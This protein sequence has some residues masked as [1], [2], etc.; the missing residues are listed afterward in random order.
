M[1]QYAQEKYTPSLL[2]A[3]GGAQLKL[4][5]L[6]CG[7]HCPADLESTSGRLPGTLHRQDI[8]KR[9]NIFVCVALSY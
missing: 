8:S 7:G 9:I 5:T 1:P 2:P 4:A 6:R 3:T